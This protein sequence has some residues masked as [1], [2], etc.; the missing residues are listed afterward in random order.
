ME[1]TAFY[2]LMPQ[3]ISIQKKNSKSKIK[4]YLLYLEKV[5]KNF[6]ANN[7]EKTGLHDGYVCNCSVESSII[8]RSNINNI[9]KY[10]MKKIDIK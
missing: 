2:L 6:T 9:Y 1:A 3:N 5:F 10:L 4:P 8:C 7:M